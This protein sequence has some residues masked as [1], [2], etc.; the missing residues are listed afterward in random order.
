[1]QDILDAILILEAL[2]IGMFVLF[3]IIGNILCWVGKKLNPHYPFCDI[4][5]RCHI[6]FAWDKNGNGWIG[7][8]MV[9]LN[10]EEGIKYLK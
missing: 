8:H 10:V 2:F 5:S 6:G 4:D 7:N 9:V 3:L 1:M